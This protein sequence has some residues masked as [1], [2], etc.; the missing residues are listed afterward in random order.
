MK[1]ALVI[2]VL[3]FCCAESTIAGPPD[4]LRIAARIVSVR[5]YNYPTHSR[6]LIRIGLG[7]TSL[8]PEHDGA[9]YSFSEG[10][11]KSVYIDRITDDSATVLVAFRGTVR[12]D[13]AMLD[14]I[15]TLR[16][17]AM[18]ETTMVAADT[19]RSDTLA[20]ADHPAIIVPL[21]EIATNRTVPPQGI[22]PTA[23]KTEPVPDHMAQV[24]SYVRDFASGLSVEPRH[25]EV[26]LGLAIVGTTLAL[27][28]LRKRTMKR[29]RSFAAVAVQAL[30]T[31]PEPEQETPV[32]VEMP[33]RTRTQSPGRMSPAMT[34]ARTYGRGQEEV[35]LS[36]NMKGRHA[37]RRWAIN[38]RKL[39]E[40][41]E[42]GQDSAAL[43]RKLGVGR[44][45][46]DLALLLHHLK[47]PRT[48]KE[49][50]A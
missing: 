34:L 39:A 21:P 33:V 32:D 3:L 6:L 37:E 9:R 48:V 49:G 14:F 43:A 13:L 11:I 28:L 15:T 29:S 30:E 4:S 18:N 50:V 26:T 24:E 7:G 12:S 47:N 10:R 22:V 31:E 25:V 36:M 1:K 5:Y 46:V 23:R 38:V 2:F 41:Q 40:E 35:N 45:E 17:D 8:K 19:T 42:T 27:I 20:T 44:G 16:L